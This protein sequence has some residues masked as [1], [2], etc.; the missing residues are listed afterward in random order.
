M[1]VVNILLGTALRL[2]DLDYQSLWFDEAFSVAVAKLTPWQILA[3]AGQ[4]VHPPFYYLL[5]HFWIEIGG[6]TDYSVRFLSAGFSILS[7]ALIYRI[8]QVIFNHRVGIWAALMLTLFPFQVQFAQETR[9]YTLILLLTLITLFAFVKAIQ[10]NKWR[11][12]NIYLVAF[13]LG[14]YTHYLIGFIIFTYHFFIAF[15]WRDYRRVWPPLLIT[16]LIALIVFLPQVIA[17]FEQAGVVFGSNYWLAS[18]PV[19]YI[20]IT[21][22]Y[23]ILGDYPRSTFM[24][25]IGLFLVLSLLAISSYQIFA[26]KPDKSTRWQLLLFMGI[27]VPIILIFTISQFKPIYLIRTL[28]ICTPFLT[29][30]LAAALQRAQFNSPLPYLT[31]ILAVLILVTFFNFYAAPVHTKEPLR[32]IADQVWQNK[33]QGDLV[34]HT[35]QWTAIPFI[36][37]AQPEENYLLSE[38]FQPIIPFDRWEAM[39]GRTL[40]INRIPSD[41]RLWLVIAPEQ[42]P[43]SQIE[44]V[45]QQLGKDRSR[46]QNDTPGGSIV[47]QLYDRV[48]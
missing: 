21:M 1:P 29:L 15:Y 31:G 3:N 9:M 5:L 18:P 22:Y 2:F 7:I 48:D 16:D 12:W 10:T 42:A 4:S 28:I 11:W 24:I 35:S 30:L 39:G 20:F 47:L 6:V 17:F 23:L 27:W 44:Q 43:G 37:Y 41:Q 40:N 14:L 33:E 32:E 8:G 19:V 45:Q 25:Y 13:I 38:P 34:V 26:R 36:V 46:L